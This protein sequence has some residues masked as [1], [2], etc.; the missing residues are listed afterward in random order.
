M[1][2][3][4]IVYVNLQL[5]IMIRWY[6]Y[7]DVSCISYAYDWICVYTIIYIYTDIHIILSLY[8]FSNLDLASMS[9]LYRPLPISGGWNLVLLNK[10][11]I[12]AGVKPPKKNR[13]LQKLRQDFPSGTT[14]SKRSS[15]S[16]AASVVPV[17]CQCVQFIAI[18]SWRKWHF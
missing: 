1:S 10:L 4:K 11:H 13:C 7:N 14:R 15:G 18:F 17:R 12:S 6:M 8:R 9:I 16:L 3:S 2:E 5:Y